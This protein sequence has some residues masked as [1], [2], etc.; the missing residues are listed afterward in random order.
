MKFWTNENGIPMYEQDCADEWLF[1]NWE[2]GSDYDGEN[3][4]EG[5][6]K[7]IDYLVE[8]SQKARECLWDNKLFGIDGSADS[9]KPLFTLTISDEEE[10]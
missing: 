6:K 4:V 7:C 3:S 5:L 10:N 9:D 1:D 2:V 8:M